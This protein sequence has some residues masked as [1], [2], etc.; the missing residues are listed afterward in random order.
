MFV[1]IYRRRRKWR[2]SHLDLDVVGL[3]RREL[4]LK[5]LRPR[6]RRVVVVPLRSVARLQTRPAIVV[7]R[8]VLSLNVESEH[9]LPRQARDKQQDR[10]KKRWK[11]RGA[12][13]FS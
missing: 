3:P 10:K 9:L 5:H 13:L 1:L 2:F 12:R 4:K 7:T 6:V 11:I 8:L